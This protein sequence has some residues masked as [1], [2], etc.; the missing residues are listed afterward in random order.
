MSPDGTFFLYWLAAKRVCYRL[1]LGSV[2]SPRKNGKMSL[3]GLATFDRVVLTHITAMLVQTG[4]LMSKP[5][6]LL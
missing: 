2:S 5:E 4:S 3:S 1:Q 6:G